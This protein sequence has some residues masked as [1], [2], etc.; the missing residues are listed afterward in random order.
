MDNDSELFRFLSTFQIP[1]LLS[2]PMSVLAPDF[3]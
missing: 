2:M 1:L 3:G